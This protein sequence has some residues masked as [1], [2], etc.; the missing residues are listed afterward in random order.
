MRFLRYRQN[1]FWSKVTF[2]FTHAH[3]DKKDQPRA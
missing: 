1:L 2:T 3:D